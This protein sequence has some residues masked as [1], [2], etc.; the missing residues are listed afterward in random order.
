MAVLPSD[1]CVIDGISRN[2]KEPRV[3]LY[4]LVLSVVSCFAFPSLARAQD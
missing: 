2:I 3:A 4:L 1:Q